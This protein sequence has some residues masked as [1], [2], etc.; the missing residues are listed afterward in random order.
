MEVYLLTFLSAFA[1]ALVATPAAREIARYF[2]LVDSP[3]GVRKLH[4]TPIPLAGGYAILLAFVVP[5]VFIFVA[6]PP[7]TEVV[8]GNASGR[9]VMLMV[10]ALVVLVMGGFDD[11]VD[12]R[13]R[14]KLLFQVIAASL[15]YAAG[16]R[17]SAVTNPFGG[18]RLTL[19]IFALPVTL[20]WFL[21]C[22][23]AIN[24][25]DGLDGLAAGVGFFAVL[26]GTI[27]AV[28]QGNSLAV[29]LCLCLLGGILGFLIYNFSPA[30]VF[31]GDAGS[32]LI[33]FL[34]AGL[35]L[36]CSIKAG[37][38]VGFLVPLLALGL[39][40]F[41]TA[42]AILRRWSRHL[43]ISAGDRRHVH[44][45]LVSMGF[46]HRKA[47]LTLYG[48]CALLSCLALLA[49]SHQDAS[50]GL[51]LA[52]VVLAAVVGAHFLGF[53]DVNE[54]L[55]RVAQDRA[56]N[57]RRCRAT[58]ET[59]KALMRMQ[60]VQSLEALWACTF[61]AFGT[62]DLDDA[63][64]T[65]TSRT[66][67]TELSWHNPE[68]VSPPDSE[69]TA[70]SRRDERNICLFVNCPNQHIEGRMELRRNGRAQPN[71][72][73]NSCVLVNR[74]RNGL[75]ERI[76]RLVGA[77]EQLVASSV[78]PGLQPGSEGAGS[79]AGSDQYC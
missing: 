1:I 66:G 72:S 58:V 77:H 46:S 16:F 47:A 11:K 20:F 38:A 6:K 3:D 63:S 9:I 19:G 48:I 14:W 36:L 39:P 26:T 23:N 15:A 4:R 8:W 52:A 50:T 73:C 74:L 54:L 28:M 43:P 34:V 22:M 35:S 25:L 33:G 51:M 61:G 2:H 62:L 57:E 24:L 55:N 44:H 67:R 5:L 10:G 53:F 79:R 76:D 69:T 70:S 60:S 65:L 78:A 29:I 40:I 21:A 27:V 56:Q 75:E 30:S 37:T 49:A 13:P 7:G 32:M 42:A 41:D 64:L 12:L 18:A 17:I 31:L 71:H 68:Q 45:V 59:E